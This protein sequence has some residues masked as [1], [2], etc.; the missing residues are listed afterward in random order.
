MNTSTKK[1]GYSLGVITIWK[2]NPKLLDEYAQLERK[3]GH[4]FRNNFK[5]T[6]IKEAIMSGVDTE[7][8]NGAW[9]M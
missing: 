2:H 4:T 8:M 1:R 5:I 3:I 9:N 7:P 6:D